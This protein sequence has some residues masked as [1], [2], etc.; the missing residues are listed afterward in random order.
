MEKPTID[1]PAHVVERNVG[2][3]EKIMKF[4]LDRPHVFSSLPDEFELVVLPDDDP[5]IRSYNLELLD[6]YGSEGK[7]VVFARI[8]VHANDPAQASV[9][10]IFVPIPV[11]A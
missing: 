4:L 8:K 3:T 9:P 5:E 7:P 2:L 6:R 1:A 11:P 10:S